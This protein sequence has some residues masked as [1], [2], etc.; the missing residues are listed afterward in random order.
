MKDEDFLSPQWRRF[1]RRMVAQ[2]HANLRDRSRWVQP[3]GVLGQPLKEAR[4]EVRAAL[5]RAIPLGLA[6]VCLVV[7]GEARAQQGAA[8]AALFDQG[9]A[10]L[11]AGDLD[12]ACARFRASDQLDPSAGARANLGTCEEKRGHVASAWDALRTALAKLPPTDERRPKIEARIAALEARLPRL[13]L[14]LEPGAPSATTAT[15]ATGAII[16]NTNTWGVALPLD[17]GPLRL[18]IAA[19]GYPTAMLEVVLIEGQTATLAVRPGQARAA[20]HVAPE[21]SSSIGPWV[22][23][24]VGVV[25]LVVGSVMGGLVL[26]KK[27]EAAA[28]CSSA[29]KTCTPAGHDAADA[30][31]TLG[32]VAT[33]G[34]VLGAAGLAAGG[35]WLGLTKAGE[36]KGMTAISVGPMMGGGA[37]KVEGTW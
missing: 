33:V 32:P 9:R 18:S 17:P 14:T 2:Q 19:P 20:E 8:A 6:L 30:G 12:T 1:F 27:S 21:T 36:K 23:G 4:A 37:V 15:D 24:G 13:V 10:A 25:G 35:I 16:G 26:T 34:F 3:T 28:G 22:V 7:P 11:A 5:A 31:S 29:S